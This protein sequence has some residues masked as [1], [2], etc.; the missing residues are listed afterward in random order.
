MH[1]F[2]GAE[3]TLIRCSIASVFLHF[4]EAIES[5]RFLVG[6]DNNFGD[7]MFDFMFVLCLMTNC[8]HIGFLTRNCHNNKEENISKPGLCGLRLFSC[9]RKKGN[10]STAPHLIFRE[11]QS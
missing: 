4:Y 5:L 1:K 3:N 2:T 10:S 8:E 6:E 7:F 11:F 9:L